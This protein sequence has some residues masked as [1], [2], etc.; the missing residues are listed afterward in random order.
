MDKQVFFASAPRYELELVEQA[1]EQ[2]LQNLA[3]AGQLEGRRFLLKPNL[4]A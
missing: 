3:A 1:V 4:L 2:V